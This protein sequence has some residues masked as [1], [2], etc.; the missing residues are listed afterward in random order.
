MEFLLHSFPKNFPELFPQPNTKNEGA[1]VFSGNKVRF[2][3]FDEIH[4]YLN[5]GAALKASQSLKNSDP[6]K[7]RI[8]LR[9]FQQTPQDSE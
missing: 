8:L 1:K 9:T 7:L 5:G 3:S 2:F 6:H 4:C